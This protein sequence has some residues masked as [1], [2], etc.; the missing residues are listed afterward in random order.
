MP[1][2]GLGTW[3]LSNLEAENAVYNAIKAG[4]RLIDKQNITI[5][6]SVWD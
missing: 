6:K 3:T 1:I 2:I 4:F 5:M